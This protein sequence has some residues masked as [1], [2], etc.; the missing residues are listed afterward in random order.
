MLKL[1]DRRSRGIGTSAAL[2]ND[3]RRYPL[4]TDG[5][6]Q[7]V[8]E[9]ATL[10]ASWGVVFSLTRCRTPRPVHQRTRLGFSGRL[11]VAAS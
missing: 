7:A 5:G 11:T 4:V 6:D 2:E 1:I 8:V 3:G 10:I 9:P